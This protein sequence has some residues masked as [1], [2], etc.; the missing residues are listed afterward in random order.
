M[1]SQ[2]LALSQER[3]HTWVILFAVKG[4]IPGHATARP[5]D[6]HGRGGVLLHLRLAQ[7]NLIR[8]AN[9]KATLDRHVL[10]S[11]LLIDQQPCLYIYPVYSLAR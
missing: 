1:P 3:R 2:L 11:I 7:D 8:T 4:I 5:M 6:T 9:P 10:E